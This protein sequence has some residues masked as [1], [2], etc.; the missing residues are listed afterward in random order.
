MVK[1]V[2]DWVRTGV[3]ILSLGER[4][5]DGSVQTRSYEN[6]FIRAGRLQDLE[7][8]KEETFTNVSMLSGQVF[9]AVLP[10]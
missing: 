9:V 8:R 6:G 3:V 2:I 4:G 5:A 7:G 10:L 1:G